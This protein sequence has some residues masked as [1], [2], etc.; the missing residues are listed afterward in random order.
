MTRATMTSRQRILAA[1][2]HERPDRLPVAPKVWPLLLE[3]Y[4]SCGW[5]SYLKLKAE[6]DHDPIIRIGAGVDGV[7]S[8]TLLA[9]YVHAGI[10]NNGCPDLPDVRLE[11]QTD[12][13]DGLSVVRK[14]FHTPAG[15]LTEVKRVPPAKGQYGIAPDPEVGEPLIK[16][17]QDADKLP[18]LLPD[19][20]L[21]SYDFIPHVTEAVGDRGLVEVRPT[22]GADALTMTAMGFEGMMLAYHDCPSLVEQVYE[23]FHRHALAVAERC[24]A[25]GMNDFLVKPVTR[26][27]MIQALV[28]YA[29]GAPEAAVSAAPPDADAVVSAAPFDLSRAAAELGIPESVARGL[30]VKFRTQYADARERLRAGFD[31]GDYA[32]VAALAHRVRGS[33]GYLQAQTLVG[34]AT[35][36]EE[37]VKSGA[38]AS[39]LHDRVVAFDRALAAVLAAAASLRAESGDTPPR[40]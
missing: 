7:H 40:T 21:G 22:R 2:R 31:G 14:T 5:E 11:Q 35:A 23:T 38:T 18:H 9:N 4:G 8:R 33:A 30:A 28:R 10:L 32:A 37:D 34:C 6:Y 24:L 19:P 13:E 29:P 25:A 16:C 3:R 39:Q 27:R 1:I 12:G 26:D 17:V 20:D 36:L 15:P